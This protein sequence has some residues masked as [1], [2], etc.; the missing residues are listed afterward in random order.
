MTN[1]LNAVLGLIEQGQYQD[2]LDKLINDLLK[3]TDGCEVSGSPD[4]NDWVRDCEAQQ[5]FYALIQEAIALLTSL[6]TGG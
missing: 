4:K 3:K 5:Q 6:T 1:K 2:A